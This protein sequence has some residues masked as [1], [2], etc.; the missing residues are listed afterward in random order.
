MR[1]LYF[2]EPDEDE[3]NSVDFDLDD[4]VTRGDEIPV[5]TK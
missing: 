1:E 4:I 3:D 2:Y 5:E